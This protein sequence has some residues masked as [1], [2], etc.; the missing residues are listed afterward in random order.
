MRFLLSSRE[1]RVKR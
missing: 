1:V